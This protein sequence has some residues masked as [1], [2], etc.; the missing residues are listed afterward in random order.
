MFSSWRGVTYSTGGVCDREREKEEETTNYRKYDEKQLCSCCN[1]AQW[2]RLS[3]GGGEFPEGRGWR[4]ERAECFRWS[5]DPSHQSTCLL[6]LSCRSE[7]HW[8]KIIQ[9]AGWRMA[10]LPAVQSGPWWTASGD[11]T[12][13]GGKWEDSR[14]S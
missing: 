3:A 10:G 9:A 14:V 4:A 6:S 7:R 1:P 2:A 11:S 5:W 13:D 12:G 8:G